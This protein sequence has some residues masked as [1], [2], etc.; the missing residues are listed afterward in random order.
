MP[1]FGDDIVG[2]DIKHMGVNVTVPT[3]AKV[4]E[5]FSCDIV[6]AVHNNGQRT[7]RYC[8]YYVME[9]KDLE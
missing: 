8:R 1:L 6:S 3:T 2:T 4:N 9:G 7:G 5:P